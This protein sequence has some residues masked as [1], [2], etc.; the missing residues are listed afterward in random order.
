MHFKEV[1]KNAAKFTPF[2]KNLFNWLEI[3]QFALEQHQRE[4]FIG[5]YRFEDLYN[6]EAPKLTSFLSDFAGTV[7]YDTTS[8]PVDKSQKILRTKIDATDQKL[9]D[10][11]FELAI[12]LGYTKEDLKQY[13]DADALQKMYSVRRR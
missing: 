8:A 5:L 13:W 10:A 11:V 12:K 1:A 7:D 4:G 2:E 9:L 6:P 3:N